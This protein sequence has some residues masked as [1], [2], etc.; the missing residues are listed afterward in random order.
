[1][2]IGSPHHVLGQGLE[3][4]RISAWGI[5]RQAKLK[6][7]I[8]CVDAVVLARAPK[9]TPDTS[10]TVPPEGFPIHTTPAPRALRCGRSIRSE[11]PLSRTHFQISEPFVVDAPPDPKT[12]CREHSSRSVNPPSW[13]PRRIRRPFVANTPRDPWTFRRG[14]SSGSEDPLWRTLLEI[15]GPFVAGAPPD[16][17]TLCCAR[18]SGS[19]DPSLRK[20][21][22]GINPPQRNKKSD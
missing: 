2:R 15:R 11:D 20:M 3:D 1:M 6:G 4:P 18:P 17:R 12:P 16:P 5:C 13:T 14:R 21:S 19:D 22:I 7:G 9:S 10:R 8:R